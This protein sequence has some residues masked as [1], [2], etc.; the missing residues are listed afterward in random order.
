MNASP[1]PYPKRAS[2]ESNPSPTYPITPNICVEGGRIEFIKLSPDGVQGPP[3][4]VP[5]PPPTPRIGGRITV[6]RGQQTS[7]DEEKFDDLKVGGALH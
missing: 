3:E 7:D 6:T 4:G 5:T 2:L 1:P